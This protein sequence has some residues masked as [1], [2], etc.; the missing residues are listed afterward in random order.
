MRVMHMPAMCMASGPDAVFFL[1]E[2]ED[3]FAKRQNNAS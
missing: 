3:F 2:D 1:K